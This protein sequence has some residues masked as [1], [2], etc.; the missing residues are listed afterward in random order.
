MLQE[1]RPALQRGSS[2]ATRRSNP[3]ATRRLISPGK[4]LLLAFSFSITLF[5]ICRQDD[6]Q[7]QDADNLRAWEYG[8][9]LTIEE[10]SIRKSSLKRTSQ[11]LLLDIAL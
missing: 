3:S 9:M 6:N 1:E 5:G 7:H 4:Y 10:D 2:S 11:N 8:V